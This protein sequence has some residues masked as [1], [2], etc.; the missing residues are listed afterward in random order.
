MRT[1]FIVIAIAFQLAA[2]SAIAQQNPILVKNVAETEIE[3]KNAKRLGCEVKLVRE[4]IRV[5]CRTTDKS[6]S[7]VNGLAWLEPAKKPPDYYDL[8]K[9]GTLASVV[10][11]IRRE[12]RARIEFTWSD[13]SRVLAIAWSP[14]APKPA[15]YFSGDAPKDLSKPACLAV[16][17]I[18]YFPGRGTMPCPD[19][20]D[21]TGGEDNGCICRK[22][23]D[24]ECT[25]DW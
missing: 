20:H 2:T 15:V 9:P 24:K 19:T 6:A 5:S 16:C 11:P 21:P 7:Q 13:F 25:P 18:P 12:T 1:L 23:R 14:S 4:W 17:G 8:V 10:L 3:V 22:Y